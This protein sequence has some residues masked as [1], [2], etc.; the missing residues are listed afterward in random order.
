[1]TKAKGSTEKAAKHVALE[2]IGLTRSS[3]Q[4]VA[5]GYGPSIQKAELADDAKREHYRLQSIREIVEPATIELEERDL[6]NGVLAEAVKLKKANKCD[7]LT[8]SRCTGSAA[9]L[10]P[11]CRSRST[12]RRAAWLSALSGRTSG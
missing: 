8:F 9:V 7:G 10:T 11:P 6:F 1:M 5:D 2:M 4:E 12:A 3:S